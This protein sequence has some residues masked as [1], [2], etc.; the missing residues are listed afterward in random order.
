MFESWRFIRVAGHIVPRTLAWYLERP[1][2]AKLVIL[3][4]ERVFTRHLRHIVPRGDFRVAPDDEIVVINEKVHYESDLRLDT[5]R[6]L[7]LGRLTNFSNGK[8]G[9]K[10]WWKGGSAKCVPWRWILNTGRVN[11][12]AW[13]ETLTLLSVEPRDFSNLGEK[14][15]VLRFTRRQTLVATIF[16]I[17]HPGCSSKFNFSCLQGSVLKNLLQRWFNAI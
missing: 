16:I 3:I 10:S 12:D 6:V 9:K 1:T 15:R 2:E 13:T 11:S 14:L 17:V 4:N 8:N 7:I 5:R